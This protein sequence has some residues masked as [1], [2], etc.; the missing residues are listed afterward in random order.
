MAAAKSVVLAP[1]SSDARDS[2]LNSTPYRTLMTIRL[3]QT[4]TDKLSND[5]GALLRGVAEGG[6]KTSG[7]A[8]QFSDLVAGYARHTGPFE[9][10]RWAGQRVDQDADHAFLD[11]PGGKPP[12]LYPVPSCRGDQR[13]RGVVAIAPAFLDRV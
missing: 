4:T 7:A 5:F 6:G 9:Q 12:V 8:K 13:R 1:G 11:L 2:P 10:P 3:S